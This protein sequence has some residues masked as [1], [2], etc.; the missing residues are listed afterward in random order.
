[1][2]SEKFFRKK[3]LFSTSAGHWNSFRRWG[4]R[5]RNICPTTP[6]PRYKVASYTTE[7]SF[8]SWSSTRT[9]RKLQTL[10]NKF[11]KKRIFQL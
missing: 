1:M 3:R 2:P 7:P 6:K 8:I 11:Y 10:W 4:S 9:T 5:M